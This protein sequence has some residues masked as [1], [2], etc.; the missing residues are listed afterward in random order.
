MIRSIVESSLRFRPLVIAIAAVVMAV[1]VARLDDMPVDVFPEVL[2]PIVQVQTEALGLSAAEVE[3]LITVPIEA[4]LLAGTAW[5]ETMRS[6][7]VPGLSS[8]ELTFK[9]GTPLMDARQM[10]QERL[11]QAHALPNVSRPPQMLQPLSFSNRVMM[12]GL[13]SEKLSLIEMSVLARWTIRPRLLGVPGVANVAIWGQRERQLQVQ[14]DPE[15]L[16]EKNVSLLQV[17][18]TTGNALWFSPLT[19]LESSVA[20]TG[21]FV[22]TPNQR[23]GV[24]H[25]L[26]ISTAADLAKVPVEDAGMRL[27]EVATVVEDH[28]PLIGDAMNGHGPGL[29]LVIEKL[30]GVNTLEVTDEIQEAL[31]ALAPGLAGV[32]IDSDVYRPAN[33]I[34]G[35]I[36]NV[37]KSLLVALVLVTVALLALFRDWRAA[38]VGVLTIPVSLM[39]AVLVIYASGA[40]IN[41]MVLAGL[42]I[43]LGVLIDDGIVESDNF[44]RRLRKGSGRSTARTILEAAFAMRG[45]MMF[46]TALVLL[47]AVPVFFMTGVPG[48]LIK[49]MAVSYGLAVLASMVVAMTV[50]PALA[51][52]LMQRLPV[53]RRESGFSGWV[54]SRYGLNSPGRSATPRAAFALAVVAAVAGIALLPTIR[55][56]PMPTFKEPDLLIQWDAEPGT[57]R[58]AMNRIIDR[59]SHELRGLPGV[60]HVGAHVGRAILSDQV[61]G[62]NSSEIWVNLDPKADYAQTVATVESVVHGYPGLD[63]DVMTYMRSRFGEALSGVDEPIVVALYGQDLNLLQSEAEKMKHA[64]AGIEGV[65]DPHTELEPQEPVVEIEVNLAAAE[66]HG[67]KPGDVRRAAATLLAGIEVGNL[68]EEQ[69]MFEVVVWGVPQIRHSVDGIHDLLID[70]PGG[71]HVRLGDIASIRVVSAPNVIR[72]EN[73]ARRVDV[74][75]DVHGRS[76]EAVAADVRSLIQSTKFPLE[77]R[78]E[79]QGDFARQRAARTRILVAAVAAGIGAWLVLQAAFGSWRLASAVV[80]T[81][82]MAL[83]GGVI[84]A[85]VGGGTLALGSLAGFLTVLGLAARQCVALVHCYRELRHDEG[86][87]FGSELVRRGVRDRAAA[88]WT[89]AIVTAAAVLP[90]VVFATAPGHE[91]LG[92]MA[93]VILGGMVTSTLYALCVVPALYARLG[94]DAKIDESVDVDLEEGRQVAV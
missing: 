62:V 44:L 50:T 75:A 42:V 16:A 4:D 12:V 77:Y 66:K 58:Q 34:R 29:L 6:E 57:S 80:L 74:A 7:S 15:R 11:T 23:L 18:K 39:A 72:R 19:F 48:E 31:D 92:P 1:G 37:A 54:Q 40:T 30:P 36:G 41:A 26:P 27:E 47:A 60:R 32:E 56:R 51:L 17:I 82:P 83:A 55:V 21:G 91:I 9:Q 28:Q 63:A 33:Y 2:P 79:L 49:P 76:A 88:I 53:G 3:Q 86:M 84:A 65:V 87:A 35:A 70:T 59:V 78:A 85:A 93:L 89:A 71:S 24:R 68:F 67:I 46:A 45:S 81:L 13:S 20:G 8:I 69:K 43:A 14:V 90:F 73:V 52:I 61:V 10:V 38:L 5:V 22:E 25:V 94:S 64:L